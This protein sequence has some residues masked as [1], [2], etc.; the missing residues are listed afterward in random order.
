MPTI[1]PGQYLVTATFHVADG[2]A[3]DDVV[4]KWAFDVGIAVDPTVIFGLADTFLNVA[5]TG[6][7][8]GLHSYMSFALS[9]GSGSITYRMYNITGALGVSS[10]HGT[11][12]FTQVG[13]LN[14][15]DFP[16]FPADLP[17][18]DALLLATNATGVGLLEHGPSETVASTES[19]I[20]Q[21]APPTHT[22]KSRPLSRSRGRMFL[23]P[24]SQAALETTGQN[25]KAELLLIAC[26]AATDLIANSLALAAPWS[27]WSKVDAVLRPI[28]HGY[29]VD[30]FATQ[31]RRR[32]ILPVRSSF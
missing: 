31:R 32:E 5:P 12:I 4:W 25:V 28:A 10:F 16:A 2:V 9:R 15:N 3:K 30:K 21:G 18:Q 26:H 14:A 27:V 8:H 29:C 6:S 20:D 1:T 23:G 19:A 7:S 17:S 13:V 22:A 24:W 11:P